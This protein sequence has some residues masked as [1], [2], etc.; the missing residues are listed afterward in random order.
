MPEAPTYE[1]DVI[2]SISDS[3]VDPRCDAACK[4][5]L[6][7]KEFAAPILKYVCTEYEG[8]ETSDI[9]AFMDD[10]VISEEPLDPDVPKPKTA[11]VVNLSNS[12]SSTTR[13]GTRF[14][15]IRFNVRAPGRNGGNVQLIINLEAQNNMAG[16]FSLLK[17]A[18]Y[19]CSRMISDQYGTV[20]TGMDYKKIRK[21]YSIW[22]CLRPGTNYADSI[23]RYSLKK[24]SVHGNIVLTPEKAADE[25]DNYDLINM[26]I[27]GLKDFDSAAQ[28][29]HPLI[30]MLSLIFTQELTA[31][32]KKEL[33]ENDYNIQM[34]ENVE[35][36]F[37]DMCDFS[38]GFYQ[39]GLNKGVK[40]G[41]AEGIGIG[42][43]EGIGIGRAEGINIGVERGIGI[44]RAEGIGIGRLEE[45][46]NT[47][48]KLLRQFDPSQISSMLDIPLDEVEKV[49]RNIA[50]N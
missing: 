7:C 4:K 2:D 6:S 22:V 46:S 23:T 3:P 43:A 29:E 16:D 32:Q 15:D 24:E 31:G 35:E 17:R 20:F 14:F 40:Q 33:L 12:E 36:A 38:T 9:I 44:G 10:A 48:K 50:Q 27:V 45:Q 1:S 13:S 11:P 37:E 5:V 25:R 42:R 30:R 49:K 47:I 34:T 41:R 21:V 19:Y 8:M 28:S 39:D 26:T 18:V